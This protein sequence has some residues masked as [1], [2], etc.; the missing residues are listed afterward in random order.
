MIELYIEIEDV[1]NNFV[2]E[3]LTL[4]CNLRE[5]LHQGRDYLITDC[6]PNIPAVMHMDIWELNSVLDEISCENP[7]M[8]AEFLAILAEAAG[9]LDLSDE[10]FLRRIKENDFLFDDISDYGWKCLTNE[11]KAARYVAERYK[12]PFDT[13]ITKEHLEQICDPALNDYI[14][15]EFVWNQYELMGFAVV[16]EP[17][18]DQLYLIHWG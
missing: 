11:E 8:T 10:D 3:N 7:G 9:V 12:V 15:W 4:P 18:L 5:S 6:V 17:E 16:E 13:G 2:V 1:D 14:A